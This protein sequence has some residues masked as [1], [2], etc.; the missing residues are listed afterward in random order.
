MRR[1]I[2]AFVIL[3]VLGCTD[4][5]SDP[6]DIKELKGNWVGIEN[7]TDTLSFET[8]F[9]DK[10]FLILKR[11]VLYRSGPYEYEILPD[12]K[13][14]IR[15]ILA[16]TLTFDEYYYK[17]AGDKLTIG[18]FFDSPSGAILTFEKID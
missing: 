17:V 1:I 10:Q 7:N 4:D 3:T 9:D 6:I 11:D 12:D 16:A 13:I 18:N 2:T 14:S 5:E 15:W 8:L